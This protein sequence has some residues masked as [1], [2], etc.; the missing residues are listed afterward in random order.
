MAE[1]IDANKKKEVGLLLHSRVR[2]EFM[3]NPGDLLDISWYSFAP[4]KL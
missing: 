1:I 4:F 3:W 2:E